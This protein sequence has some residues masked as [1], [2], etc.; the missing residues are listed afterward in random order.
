MLKNELY[1]T[2]LVR[3]AVKSGSA[4]RSMRT[5]SADALNEF[6]A[7]VLERF[8]SLTQQVES[9]TRKYGGERMGC[10]ERKL[11]S[12]ETRT[13][14]DML[15]FYRFLLTGMYEPVDLEPSPSMALAAVV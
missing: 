1:L 3:P 12:G 5:R 11:A 9:S 2:L 7:D 14:S 15:G 4:I 13:S 6:D 10:H 8:S